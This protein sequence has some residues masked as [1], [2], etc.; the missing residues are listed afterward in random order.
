MQTGMFTLKAFILAYREILTAILPTVTITLLSAELTNIKKLMQIPL[1]L[2][3]VEASTGFSFF[4]N[5]TFTGH[6]FGSYVKEANYGSEIDITSGPFEFSLSDS[7]HA[8]EEEHDEGNN[9]DGGYPNDPGHDQD[10]AMEV[11]GG[12]TLV[13]TDANWDV[14]FESIYFGL[15]G[16]FDGN[17]TNGD[18]NPVVS[19]TYE[20]Q[21]IDADSASLSYV[22]ASTGFSF[23]L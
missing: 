3:Y 14:Y 5:L 9:T 18:N 6:G 16:N 11:I 4:Y 15:Q 2:S 22:E 20:Y 19:G 12:A 23:F 21:K 13:A 10:F 1:S 8:D 7:E 17:I